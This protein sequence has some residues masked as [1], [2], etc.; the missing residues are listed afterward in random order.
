VT[1]LLGTMLDAAARGLHVFPLRP[2]TKIPATPHGQ[3]DGTTDAQQITAWIAGSRTNGYGIHCEPSGLYVVDVDSGTGKVGAAT[4]ATLTAAHGTV[5]TYAV[6]TQSGGTH[7]Y[8]RMPPEPLANTASKLG[9]DVDT[10]GNG[11]VV[12]PGSVVNGNRY[13]VIADLPIAP[14]P[15]WIVEAVRKPARPIAPPTA[16]QNLFHT[17]APARD[18]AERVR[19][20]AEELAAAPE[21]QG[22]DTAARLAFMAGGYVGAGQIHRDDAIGILLDG[23][24]GWTYRSSADERTMQNTIIRQV[25]EGTGSPRPWQ[26][27]SFPLREIRIVDDPSA[28][29]G[30]GDQDAEECP[31]TGDGA[32]GDGPD[33]RDGGDEV[34]KAA[35]K[36]EL[37][38][39]SDWATDGGQGRW[40]AKEL[41]GVAW[42]PGL[43]WMIWDGMR[44]KLVE[45]EA[46]SSIV[47]RF[48]AEQFAVWA[49]KYRDAA[50]AQIDATRDDNGDAEA[51]AKAGMKKAEVMAAVMKNRQ[52]SSAVAAV[53]SGLRDAVYR[54]AAEFDRDPS[55]LNTPSGT[56]DLRTGR[57]KQHDPNDLITKVTVGRFAPG[58]RHPDWEA[59]KVALP[60]G[61]LEWLQVRMGAA[62]AGMQ[63][64]DDAVFLH[65]GGSNGKSLFSNDGIVRAL[66]DYAMLKSSDLIASRKADASAATPDK[67]ELR[68]AR[69][70]LIEELPEEFAMSTKAVKEL[71]GTG[72]ITARRLYQNS[73]TFDASHSLFINTNHQPNVTDTDWGTWRRLTMVT[74][75]F[76]F[77]ASPVDDTDRPGD[78]DLVHRIRANVDGQHDAIVTWLVEGAQMAFGDASCLTIGRRDADDRRAE[79]IK[80]ATRDWRR[81][82]DKLMAYADECLVLDPNSCIARADLLWHFNRWMTE[83]GNTKWSARLLADRMKGHP[84]FPKVSI[85]RPSPGTDMDRPLPAGSTFSS[86]LPALAA[87][88]EVFTNLRFAVGV[89]LVKD[90]SPFGAVRDIRSA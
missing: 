10:R 20:L 70:V 45:S 47:R 56:V 26:A 28:L 61:S 3:D 36:D 50:K 27:A 43:S 79:P 72:A 82:C 29:A 40:L 5:D 90:D 15:D 7:L 31:L 49:E 86:E 42:A 77:T 35:K 74:F 52:K 80:E 44:W 81:A 60:P 68:G 23:I 12:G 62:T 87:R 88:P 18:V 13:E 53:L 46:V 6:R 55:L 76:T 33:S 19:Q 4:W 17:A 38:S 21:G 89:D 25:D 37:T 78:R 64:A 59:A 51:K 1:D 16:A 39:L 67:A 9:K 8:Y 14:L 66:G 85:G 83:Q 41:P 2:N 22:N 71:A 63:L 69:F 11:Y 73:I 75:P 30:R 32:D 65:G 58:Y 54:E 84:S 34:S 57:I 48:Y 24:S